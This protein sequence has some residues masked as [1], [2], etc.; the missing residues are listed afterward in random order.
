MFLSQINKNFKNRKKYKQLK[1]KQIKRKQIISR[2]GN[3]I[4]QP[5]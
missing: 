1:K 2:K 4:T 5:H 3:E